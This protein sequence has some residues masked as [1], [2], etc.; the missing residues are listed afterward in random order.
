MK[1][2]YICTLCILHLCRN[3]WD[4]VAATG[5]TSAFAVSVF[6]LAVGKFLDFAF[7][8]VHHTPRPRPLRTF[9]RVLCTFL[10]KG[11]AAIVFT[12]L[13][14]SRRRNDKK[15]KIRYLLKEKQFHLF[16]LIYFCHY[17][18]YRFILTSHH[19]IVY[20]KA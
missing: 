12:V 8:Y 6:V 16:L 10:H 13:H 7:L 5:R 11:A 4:F 9:M 14:A 20:N 2:Y 3:C 19:E 17:F 15:K 18:Y 1:H